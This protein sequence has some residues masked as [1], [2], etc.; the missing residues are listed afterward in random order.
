MK[1]H[2]DPVRIEARVKNNVLWHAIYDRHGSVAKFCRKFKFCQTAVSGLL[3]LKVPIY[4]TKR[5]EV[6]EGEYNS[7]CIKLSKVLNVSLPELF[8]DKLYK[9]AQKVSPKAVIETSLEALP[10]VEL[11]SLPAPEDAEPEKTFDKEELET[12]VGFCLSTLTEREEKMLRMSFGLKPYD[13]EHTLDE[14]GAAIGVCRNRANQI[15]HKGLRKL[16]HSK[17][18]RFTRPF[19]ESLTEKDWKNPLFSLDS[20][21][22]AYKKENS[23]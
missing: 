13:K 1:K 3:N 14:M 19:M 9:T 5:K 18:Q 11:L 7:L 8:S 6:Q 20:E 16:R 10:A 22:A 21:F 23:K 12:V 4:K 17:R 15:L 2:I